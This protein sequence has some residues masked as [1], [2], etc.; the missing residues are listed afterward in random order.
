MRVTKLE[1]AVCGV[2]GCFQKYFFFDGLLYIVHV[3]TYMWVDVYVHKDSNFLITYENK[4]PQRYNTMFKYSIFATHLSVT[5]IHNPCN[6]NLFSPHS[7]R[8]F[9]SPSS[10]KLCMFPFSFLPL[11]CFL[12]TNLL[13]QHFHYSV[14]SPLHPF[15][16]NTERKS[17][18]ITKWITR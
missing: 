5:F 4:S 8:F 10:L 17:K 2:S 7:P 11:S 16:P 3:Y 15:L 13:L 18:V 12:K 1:K 9:F 6:L 14:H